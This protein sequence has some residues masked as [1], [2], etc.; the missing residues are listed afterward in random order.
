MNATNAALSKAHQYLSDDLARVSQLIDPLNSQALA[1]LYRVQRRLEDI[2]EL[3][4]SD[5]PL[6]GLDPELEFIDRMHQILD[7]AKCSALMLGA[8]AASEEEFH[9][10]GY[11]GAATTIADLI[12]E[13]FDRCSA[14]H[15]ARRPAKDA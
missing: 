11:V 2:G 3:V 10:D 15:E 14:W 6:V 9:H 4:K 1:M 12:Q 13:A 8:A 5:A 7:K